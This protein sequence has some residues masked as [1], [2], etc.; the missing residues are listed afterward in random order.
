MGELYLGELH[1]AG[2]L[3]RGSYAW[4]E[5][6]FLEL[7]EHHIGELHLLGDLFGTATLEENYTGGELH[8][9]ELHFAGA[10]LGELHLGGATLGGATLGTS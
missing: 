9:E 6:Y 3:L 5:L 1:F 10:R 2:A 4:E 7:H 8:L